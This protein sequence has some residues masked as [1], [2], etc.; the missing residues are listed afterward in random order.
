MTNTPNLTFPRTL[1][2]RS[3]SLAKLS[4]RARD[5]VLR[6]WRNYIREHAVNGVVTIEGVEYEVANVKLDI[7]SR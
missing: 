6:G 7:G 1:T 2:E 3:F 4:A 5:R